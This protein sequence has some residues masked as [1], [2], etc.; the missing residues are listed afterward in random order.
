MGRDV[1]EEPLEVRIPL[2]RFLPGL[3]ER[4]LLRRPRARR[5]HRATP[6]ARR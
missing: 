4:L 5:T 3:G 1:G 2:V 6:L